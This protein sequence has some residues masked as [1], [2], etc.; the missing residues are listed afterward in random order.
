[1]AFVIKKPQAKSLGELL[2]TGISKGIETSLKAKLEGQKGLTQYQ[3][4]QTKLRAKD[5]ER[6]IETAMTQEFLKLGDPFMKATGISA[7]DVL[8]LSRSAIKIMKK[9]NMEPAVAMDE[10]VSRFQTQKSALEESKLPTFNSS[11][12]KS[13]K[14]DIFNSIKNGNITNRTLINRELIAKKWPAKERL[15]I[16]NNLKKVN[17]AVQ[18]A[19]DIAEPKKGNLKQL[20]KEE[21]STRYV[22]MPGKTHKQ[23]LK[24][25]KKTLVQE[26]Y[27]IQGL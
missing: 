17:G 18:Q 2:G 8:P 9:E 11:K 6:K 26:G 23:K 4:L 10:A 13:L 14:E 24:N 15:A 22:K 7:N 27:S 21:L 5:Q 16:L 25:L 19:T 1:M 20:S 3:A 12:I